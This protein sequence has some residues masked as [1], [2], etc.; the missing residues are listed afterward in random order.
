MF[1][2][3][4]AE[5]AQQFNGGGFMPSPGAQEGQDTGAKK[6]YDS[7]KVVDDIILDVMKI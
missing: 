2:G 7:Q 1:G 5:D 4:F 3:A 6:S